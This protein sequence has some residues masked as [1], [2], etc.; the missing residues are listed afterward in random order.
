M[1]KL[2]DGTEWEKEEIVKR[3]DDDSFYYGYLGEAA[4]SSSSIKSL[5]DSPVKY[6]HYLTKDNSNIP[7]LRE[8]RLFH[9]MLLEYQK[10]PDKYAFVDASSRNTNK[11]KDVKA[12]N[13]T[14]EVMLEKELRS[15]SYLI[16]C[17][18]SNY[19]ASELLRDG[20]AEV[21][22]VGEIFDFPF[23]GKADYVKQGHLIDVK[24]TSSIDSWLSAARYKWHYNVQAW[25]YMQLFSIQKFTFLVI[26]K[27]SGEIGIYE[28]SEESLVEAEEKV[29]I[30]CDNY[31]KYFYNKTDNVNEYVRKGFI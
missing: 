23:R 25:L 7:A 3:M 5:V 9:A 22:T 8:G 27:S 12:E 16:K 26:D 15:M 11:Y 1:I 29:K 4:L 24:T 2:L 18:E 13:P 6:K 21:A 19:E 20:I 28:C 10:L 14:K 30:A 17:I 31:S